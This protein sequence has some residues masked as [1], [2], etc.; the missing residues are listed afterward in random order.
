[1]TS[2]VSETPNDSAPESKEVKYA[3]IMETSGEECESWYYFIKYNGNEKNLEYLKQQI[4]QIEMYIIDDLSTF[5][6]E[7]E[8]LVSEKTAKEMSKLEINSVMFHRKF[9]GKL[10]TIN[11]GLKKKDSNEKRIERINTKL[12]LGQIVDYV[13]DEDIDSEDLQSSS[14]ET[15]E[16][17]HEDDEDLIPLP[18]NK[19]S[20]A[21]TSLNH[22][23]LNDGHEAVGKE[24]PKKKKKKKKKNRN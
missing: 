4:E 12:A 6:I 10:K 9:D 22:L 8:H 20:T 14:E 2:I 5:D 15:S 23:S 7:L 17:E 13:S 19:E 16:S 3:T 18:F 21:S 24:Q 11:L 1:M